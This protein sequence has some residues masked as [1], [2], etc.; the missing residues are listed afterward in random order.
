[1]TVSNVNS[2][3]AT[4][5]FFYA[6]DD[7]PP[8]KISDDTLDGSAVSDYTFNFV[9]PGEYTFTSKKYQSCMIIFFV[10]PSLLSDSD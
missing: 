5:L 9:M 4:G 10:F 3:G 6:L 7:E 8:F 1:M 2:Y